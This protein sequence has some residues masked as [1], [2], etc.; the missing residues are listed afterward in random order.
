MTLTDAERRSIY[1]F[2]A[3]ISLLKTDADGFPLPD[4]GLEIEI[5][6]R[7]MLE[8]DTIFLR[9]G[10]QLDD[11]DPEAVSLLNLTEATSQLIAAT[12]SGDRDP[13]IPEKWFRRRGEL[14]EPKD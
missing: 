9:D 4:Q 3:V 6:G 12:A 2:K 11:L 5:L 1:L 13:A 14:V 7:K 8:V 10:I